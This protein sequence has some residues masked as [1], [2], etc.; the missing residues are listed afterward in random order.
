MESDK[1]FSISYS[2]LACF[3]RCRQRY[4]WQYINKFFPKSSEGQVRGSAGHA[5][6]AEWHKTYDAETALKAA[7]M[8]WSAEGFTEGAGW[9]L[10][11]ETLQRYFQWSKENDTFRILSSEQKFEIVFHQPRVKFIG[12]IDGVVLQEDGRIWLLEN[13][14]NKRVETQHLVMDAQASAY[15]LAAKLLQ[16]EAVGVLYNIIRVGTK[17]AQTDPVV[18]ASLYRNSL[19]LTYVQHEILRQ[20]EEM[21]QY[22]QGGVP[23]RNPTKD[24]S[25]DCPFFTACLDLLEDGIES[26]QQL[27]LV[28]NLNRK[29]E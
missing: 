25:W 20:A 14:F 18:R 15:L 28:C 12:Y 6:L 10:T 19:G 1:I 24:C 2:K 13:K 27:E 23:Y 26:T 4:H 11:E 7:W 22:E 9:D 16:Q 5:A 8:K 3:R 17:L 21:I 29:D